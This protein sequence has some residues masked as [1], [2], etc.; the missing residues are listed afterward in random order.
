MMANFF[1]ARTVGGRKDRLLAI[2]AGAAW[3]YTDSPDTF[4][5]ETE[6][7]AKILGKVVAKQPICQF[8]YLTVLCQEEPSLV[9]YE[10]EYLAF[11]A[12]LA[13]AIGEAEK[14]TCQTASAGI[15]HSYL[16]AGQASRIADDLDHLSDRLRRA[17]VITFKDAASDL[18][19][20][21]TGSY[22]WAKNLLEHLVYLRLAFH[23]DQRSVSQ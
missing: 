17:G 21:V 10:R 12:N 20:G 19:A 4:L 2:R 3:V 15:Y 7:H 22:Y 18:Y 5:R 13:C 14:V 11:L 9:R 8:G 23:W 6:A 16:A 1:T